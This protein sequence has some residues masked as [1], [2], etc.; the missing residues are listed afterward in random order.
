MKFRKDITDFLIENKGSDYKKNIF[1]IY[2]KE[3]VLYMAEYEFGKNKISRYG[4]Y[5]LLWHESDVEIKNKIEEKFGV[6]FSN[7]NVDI[8]C[9]CGESKSF[10]SF[11]GSYEILLRCN[12][13]GNKFSAYSG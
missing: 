4:S 9:R 12:N 8:V 3:N 11:Y 2:E 5:C 6:K 1:K 7:D 10:S 13:C